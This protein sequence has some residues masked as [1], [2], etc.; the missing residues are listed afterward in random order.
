MI[1]A[2]G[3]LLRA[4]LV[5]LSPL[6]ELIVTRIGQVFGMGFEAVEDASFARFHLRTKRFHV[7]GT[8]LTHVLH[9]FHPSTT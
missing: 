4:S 3:V 1:L 6:L 8:S 2:G 5:G 9:P 7:G